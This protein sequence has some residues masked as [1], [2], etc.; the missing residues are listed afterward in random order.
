[1]FPIATYY[2]WLVVQ[3]SVHLAG[4]WD[5]RAFLESGSQIGSA[6]A[7]LIMPKAAA[8][9]FKQKIS[10][11]RKTIIQCECGLS[12]MF[13]VE[14]VFTIIN[15]TLFGTNKNEQNNNFGLATV[16]FE[17]DFES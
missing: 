9:V 16:L 4:G 14:T 8:Y 10:A 17:V 12:C 7:S 5:M 6:A 1:M 15:K 11:S 2:N 13:I 3:L